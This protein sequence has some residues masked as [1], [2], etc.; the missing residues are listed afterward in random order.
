MINTSDM[1]NIRFFMHD[2]RNRF[3]YI[4]GCQIANP[5]RFM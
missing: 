1:K 5:D 3:G 4:H 2:V